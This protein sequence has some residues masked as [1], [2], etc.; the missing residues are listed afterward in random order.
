MKRRLIVTADDFGLTHGISEAI[1]LAYR[2]GIVTT[3]SLMVNGPAFES[4][5][6][7]A[8][9]QPDLNLGLHLNL[10]QGRSICD[11]AVIP[12]L[13][14]SNGFIYDDSPASWPISPFLGRTT[15]PK[16]R[17]YIL[18]ARSETEPTLSA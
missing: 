2:R 5:V 17:R 18:C 16:R 3:T 11:P 14:G 9:Q 10:T 13:A 4:A 8:R 1:V 12:S 6:A 7:L 15:S